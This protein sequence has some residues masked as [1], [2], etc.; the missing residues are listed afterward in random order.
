[1]ISGRVSATGK[2][3]DLS[4]RPQ[5][6][7]IPIINMLICLDNSNFQL[8]KVVNRALIATLKYPCFSAQNCGKT[9]SLATT[10]KAATSVDG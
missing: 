10:V 5:I 8:E 2:V 3:Q 1:M 7:N 4:R 6:H 9:I